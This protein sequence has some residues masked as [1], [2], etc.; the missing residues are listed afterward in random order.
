[1]ISGAAA[2]TRGP[3]TW[4]AIARITPRISLGVAP[5]SSALDTCH[6]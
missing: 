6:R 2:T 3:P 1:M 4:G 5:A